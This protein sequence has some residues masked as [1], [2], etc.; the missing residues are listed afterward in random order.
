[1]TRWTST[2]TGVDDLRSQVTGPV[3]GGD[4]TH[5]VTEHSEFNTVADHAPVAVVRAE[6]VEDVAAAVR[7]ATRR[8]LGVAV[9]ATG[10]G[11]WSYRG[12][13]VVS[14]RRMTACSVDA[15]A[16]TA[17]VG[18]GVRWETVIAAAAAH[19]LAPLNGSSPTVGVVGY[20]LGG[21]VGALARQ[22]GFA[23]DHVRSFDLVTADGA[24]VHV[25][26]ASH[27]D[28]YWAVL[29][30]PGSFGVVTRLQF[31]LMPVRQLYGGSLYYAAEQAGAVLDAFR[32]WTADVPDATTASIALL[33]AAHGLASPGRGGVV[34]L[35]F[36][37][38]GDSETGAQVLAPLR[39]CPG[40]LADTVRDMPYAAVTDILRDPREPAPSHETGVFLDALDADA[41]AALLAAVGSRPRPPL[42]LVELRHLGGALGRLPVPTNC[43]AGRD[44][45]FILGIAA[46]PSPQPPDTV[47]APC[48]EVLEAMAPWA[49]DVVPIK[50]VH[51]SPAPVSAWGPDDYGRLRRI[52]REHDPANTFRVGPTIQP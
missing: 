14:T 1:M 10:H 17:T 35:R 38:V 49:A 29:G 26:P 45:A 6:D 36:A 21:G 31:D 40:V 25:T 43:V 51:Q 33:P 15:D 11:S 42:A 20:T 32:T 46:H 34:H 4:E 39:G 13:V 16:R 28:L 5:R 18:A 24:S 41:I 2:A 37:H 3:H 47:P 50:Y 9:H 52:K 27:P 12:A 22:Y 19:G 44:A 8:G 30:A 7:W 48:R 23:A